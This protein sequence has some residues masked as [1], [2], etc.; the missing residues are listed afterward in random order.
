M[1]KKT[2]TPYVL[3][4]NEKVELERLESLYLPTMRKDYRERYPYYS[5]E[6]KL[7]TLRSKAKRDCKAT[8]IKTTKYHSIEEYL[9]SK[10]SIDWLKM[11]YG[12]IESLENAFKSYLE[13]IVIAKELLIEERIEKEIASLEEQRSD[14][15]S[16]ILEL[17]NAKKD[18]LGEFV[19]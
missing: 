16:K 3:S 9:A 5:D 12:M 14:I 1:K 8:E 18:I 13:D 4:E 15:D 17:Q 10:P 7:Q 2:E 19:A 11:D 6:E